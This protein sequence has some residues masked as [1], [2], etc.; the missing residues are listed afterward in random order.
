MSRVCLALVIGVSV[1]ALAVGC[2]GTVLNGTIEGT[3][4][5]AADQ[6]VTTAI[7]IATMGGAEIARVTTNTLGQYKINSLEP[8]T[9]DLHA[10]AVGYS[11]SAVA[12]VT[13]LR[14]NTS[15]RNLVLQAL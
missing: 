9:Y 12:Q 14:A 4:H 8:N 5:N 6:P 13:V 15:T 11:P 7:V 3:V 1:M 10:E 2:T